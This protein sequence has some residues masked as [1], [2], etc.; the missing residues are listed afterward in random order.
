MFE[1][2]AHFLM[3]FR[4]IKQLKE[5]GGPTLALVNDQQRKGQG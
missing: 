1:N 2:K 3:L 4:K 5:N